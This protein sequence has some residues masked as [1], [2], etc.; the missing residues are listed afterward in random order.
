MSHTTRLA[1]LEEAVPAPPDQ[2]RAEAEAFWHSMPTI[3]LQI[4]AEAWR[5]HPDCNLLDPQVDLPDWLRQGLLDAGAAGRWTGADEPQWISDEA[6]AELK[7]WLEAN[8]R[9]L[10]HLHPMIEMPNYK[11][12][13]WNL[14][15]FMWDGP[16]GRN[17]YD[18]VQA[19]RRLRAMYPDGVPAPPE[20]AAEAPEPEPPKPAAA[21]PPRPTPALQPTAVHLPQPREWKPVIFGVPESRWRKLGRF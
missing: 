14:F 4:A 7:D 20:P 3:V 18:A 10:D 16:N 1:K 17:A 19:V 5:A 13:A 11:T 8:H 6:F 9:G 2:E 21:E 15:I 12:S